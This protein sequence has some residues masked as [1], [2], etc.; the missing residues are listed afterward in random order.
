MNKKLFNDKLMKQIIDKLPILIFI[1]VI[2][3]YC[4]MNMNDF[5]GTPTMKGGGFIQFGGA[6]RY[7]P[8]TPFLYQM[9]YLV[10]F[11][12]IFLII[13]NIYYAYQSHLVT[14][15]SFYESGKAFLTAFGN[16]FQDVKNKVYKPLDPEAQEYS[17]FVKALGID[18][19]PYTKLFCNMFAPCTCCGV[20]DYDP[21]NT[22]LSKDEK[23]ANKKLCEGVPP[24]KL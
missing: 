24:I 3:A 20:G 6:A 1:I 13:F 19:A 22:Y 4:F 23:D 8:G 2:A 16:R 12:F 5:T 17:L 9:R 18:Y 14:N 15:V 11:F 7:P 10:Y 21:N